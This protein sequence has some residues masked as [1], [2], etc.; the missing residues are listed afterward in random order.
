M[1]WAMLHVTLSPRTRSNQIFLVN[2][3]PPKLL[4]IAISNIAG[5]YVVCCRGYSAMFRVFP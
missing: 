2:A 5:A 3:F 4:D 1:Y